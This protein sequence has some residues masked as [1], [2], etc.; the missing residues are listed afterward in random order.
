VENTDCLIVIGTALETGLASSIV[1]KCIK[2]K[3]CPVIEVNLESCID[4][5][6]N[7]KVIQ[8]SEI[9]LPAMFDE[10]YKLKKAKVSPK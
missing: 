9:A 2:K 4:V 8:K 1:N 10:Y 6:Y 3:E 5:G 7:L